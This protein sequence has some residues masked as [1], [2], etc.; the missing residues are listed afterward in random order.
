M[1]DVV[2]KIDP[3]NDVEA[4]TKLRVDYFTALEAG[5][6][7]RIQKVIVPAFWERF[8]KYYEEY[9]KNWR[10]P[11][12]AYLPVRVAINPEQQREM[13]L[14]W[15]EQVLKGQLDIGPSFFIT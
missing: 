2:E 13:E 14:A 1:A 6:Y 10:D 5:D 12:L 15:A 7:Y 8:Q 4:L 9:S 11:S 3:S